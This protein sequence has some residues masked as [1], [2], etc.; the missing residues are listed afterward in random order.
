MTY[1]DLIARLET[2]ADNAGYPRCDLYRE[3]AAALRAAPAEVEPT[4]R[5]GT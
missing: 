1:D 4:H 5:E 2:A 3:A